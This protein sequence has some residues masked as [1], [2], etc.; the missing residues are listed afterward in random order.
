MLFRIVAIFSLVAGAHAGPSAALGAYK[1][2]SNVHEHADMMLDVKAFVS[3]VKEEDYVLAKQIYQKGGGQSCKSATKA[4][5]LQG[6]AQK[7]LS[8]ESYAAAFYS[9]ETFKSVSWWDEWF[10]AG[11]DATGPWKDLAAKVR[12]V[13]L[14]KGAMGLM[15]W[16]AAHELEAAVDKA[17]TVDKRVD[18]IA[19]HAWDEGWAF[20]Y[21]SGDGS[22]SPWEV[23]KK[24]D[25]DF[26]D[27]AT[28]TEAILP[29]F[30]TGLVAVRTDTYD[31][32]KAVESMNV[33][34]DMWTVTYLRA[35]L[36]YLSITEKSYNEKAHAE[37]YAYYLAIEG[38]V[39]SKCPAGGKAMSDAL[40]ITKKDG[41]FKSGTY[42]NVKKEMEKCYKAL[43]IS[44]EM[45]GEYKDAGV[46]GVKCDAPPCESEDVKLPSTL[47]APEVTGKNPEDVTCEVAA[48]TSAPTQDASSAVFSAVGL[49]TLGLCSLL[50]S[51]QK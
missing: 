1:P 33:I 16:Y 12:S 10:M 48:P 49:A 6:F 36:K 44:C 45:M 42:C 20:Y 25:A 19:P 17:K 47:D 39:A 41:D 32:D 9:V 18:T 31:E 8:T 2:V 46:K 13:A 34:Y 27:G 4:R 50:Q 40:A 38:W 26:P 30:N 22:G 21:G 37:G 11:L 3:A 43:R 51:W 29:Y 14:Q 28:V 7:D 15:S 35:A 5:T 23:A 24:R